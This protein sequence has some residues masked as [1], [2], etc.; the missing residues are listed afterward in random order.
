MSVFLKHIIN[1]LLFNNILNN[2]L[3]KYYNTEI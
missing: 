1:K 3:M 2:N